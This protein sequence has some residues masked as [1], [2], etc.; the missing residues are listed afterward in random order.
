MSEIPNPNEAYRPETEALKLAEA[1]TDCL[2]KG[3]TIFEIR[4]VV[5]GVIGGNAPRLRSEDD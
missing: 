3:M 5:D 4:E 2:D 1:V